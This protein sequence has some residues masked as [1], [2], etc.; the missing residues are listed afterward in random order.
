MVSLNDYG[1]LSPWEAGSPNNGVA[2]TYILIACRHNEMRG[3]GQS[4]IYLAPVECMGIKRLSYTNMIIKFHLMDRWAQREVQVCHLVRDLAVNYGA[5]RQD[6]WMAQWK[7]LR[8]A[9]TVELGVIQNRTLTQMPTL[10]LERKPEEKLALPWIIG[11]RRD[12]NDLLTKEFVFGCF[13]IY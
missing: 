7:T 3:A 8:V 13:I 9:W 11:S 1:S 5:G 6:G 12:T 10:F 2:Q 4:G